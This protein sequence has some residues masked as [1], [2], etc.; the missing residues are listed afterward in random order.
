MCVNPP[1][2]VTGERSLTSG[3]T[4][5]PWMRLWMLMVY[6][7]VTTSLMAER[8]FF[9]SPFLGAIYTHTHTDI[10]TTQSHTEYA[11]ITSL[12]TSH[13]LTKTHQYQPMQTLFLIVKPYRTRTYSSETKL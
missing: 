4:Y 7:R 6:S 11:C 8:P 1:V 5:M 2:R 13:S 9:F 10:N 12:D 3:V